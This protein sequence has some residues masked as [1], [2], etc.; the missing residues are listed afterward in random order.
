MSKV[1]RHK[2]KY[3]GQEDCSSSPIKRINGKGI[4][5][6]KALTNYLRNAQKTG[7]TVTGDDIKEKARL[8]SSTLGISA[9]SY[10]K[11][12]GLAWL[13]KFMLKQGIDQ[14]KLLR[15]V[16]ETNIPASAPSPLSTNRSDEDK[17]STG[18][19][20]DY[21]GE[22]NAYKHPSSQNT[23]SL[24]SA[25][26]EA[27][28]ASFSGSASS[29]TASFN[30]SPNLNLGGFLTA[31]QDRQI[32]P[33]GPASSFQR[34]RSQKF[35]TLDIGRLNQSQLSEPLTPKY[36]VP[37]TAPSSALE[38]PP[39][40]VTGAPA[41][42]K[43]ATSLREHES[44]EA[45]TL[46]ANSATDCSSPSGD[47]ASLLSMV[48]QKKALLNRLMRFFHII[49]SSPPS[50]NT[51]TKAQESGEGETNSPTSA[52]QPTTQGTQNPSGNSSSGR[53]TAGKRQR[54]GVGD[55]EDGDEGRDGKRSRSSAT[56]TPPE[57]PLQRFAC[58]FFKNN[59]AKYC[60]WRSC[61]GP[62]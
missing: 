18:T 44:S 57:L 15:R 54:G 60:K 4:D 35:P 39:N 41:R 1:L 22:P 19:F 32:P 5:I 38:S 23:T 13:N 25:S 56:N 29:P 36:H 62:G 24:S 46:S 9:D 17:D 40:E 45:E 26:T 30:F 20:M 14:P 11:T 27:T 48:V 28:A 33:S 47:D 43:S 8:F 6:E 21:I 49:L 12:D 58:P 3:L 7:I 2:E 53:H 10:G 37:S 59:Q 42:G 34:S 61:L 50:W 55:T 31:V 16:S 52:S 51:C